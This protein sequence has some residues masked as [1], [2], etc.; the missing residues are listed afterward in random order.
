MGRPKKLKVQSKDLDD[1]SSMKSE[2]KTPKKKTI[3]KSRGKSDVDSKGNNIKKY[4][5]LIIKT[6]FNKLKEKEELYD[7]VSEKLN[8]DTVIRSILVELAIKIVFIL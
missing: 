1:N 3:S 5:K 8:S 7:K 2:E 6:Y 4:K